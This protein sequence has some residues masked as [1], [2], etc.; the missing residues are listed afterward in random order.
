MDTYIDENGVE[1]CG[2]CTE[3]VG[4]T[5]DCVCDECGDRTDECACS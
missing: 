3:P 1:C 2:F 5:C 4:E